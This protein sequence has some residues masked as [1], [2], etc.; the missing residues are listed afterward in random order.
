MNKP[1]S[2]ILEILRN[3]QDKSLK[4]NALI[5]SG[6]DEAV[7]WEAEQLTQ[8]IDLLDIVVC[9]IDQRERKLQQLLNIVADL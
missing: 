1:T 8:Q 6:Q 7:V 3:I 9:S 2:E 5:Q 4:V